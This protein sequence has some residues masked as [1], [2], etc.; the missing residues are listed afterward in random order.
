[1]M[2]VFKKNNKGIAMISIMITIAFLS[3][4]ATALLSISYS[5]YRMKVV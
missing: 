3:I 5:N 4:I 1:M 2:K